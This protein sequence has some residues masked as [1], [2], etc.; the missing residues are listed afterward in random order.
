MYHFLKHKVKGEC[1][2]FMIFIKEV[3]TVC[4]DSRKIYEIIE[5]NYLKLR[6]RKIQPKIK[7]GT[8]HH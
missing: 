3:N 5:E 2:F 8:S 4:V 6:L 1:L 7:Y